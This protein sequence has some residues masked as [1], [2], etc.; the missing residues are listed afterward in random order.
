MSESDAVQTFGLGVLRPDSRA[1]HLSDKA[2]PQPPPPNLWVAK[3]PEVACR[4][5]GVFLAVQDVPLPGNRC[6]FGSRGCQM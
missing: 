3:C 6:V 2:V 1:L 5:T 4:E